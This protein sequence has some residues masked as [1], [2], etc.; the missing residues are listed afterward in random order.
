MSKF[1]RWRR[2]TLARSIIALY[3]RYRGYW[4]Q[5]TFHISLRPKHVTH[6][7]IPNSQSLVSFRTSD[8]DRGFVTVRAFPSVYSLSAILDYLL[9]SCW[10]IFTSIDVVYNS[11]SLPRSVILIML[12]TYLEFSVYWTNA[13]TTQQ[14]NDLA[15]I[16]NTILS[17][18]G[19]VI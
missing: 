7:L 17:E 5:E 2:D 10:S 11:Y 15:S 19:Q 13:N 1:Q 8:F 16:N 6:L 12:G 3:R 18:H 9:I 14:I 4:T